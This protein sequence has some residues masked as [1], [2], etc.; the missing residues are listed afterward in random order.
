MPR[1]RNSSILVVLAGLS[2][3][4]VFIYVKLLP[5]LGSFS[6][7]L[8]GGLQ[9][10][11]ERV[12]VPPGE[13]AINNPAVENRIHNQGNLQVEAGV[14]QN[15]DTNQIKQDFKPQKKVE[16]EDDDDN[17]GLKGWNFLW[18]KGNSGKDGNEENDVC[19]KRRAIK[20]FKSMATSFGKKFYENVPIFVNSSNL[21]FPESQE[22]QLPFGIDGSEDKFLDAL[23][24]L[25]KTDLPTEITNASCSRCIIVG[26]GGIIKDKKLGSTIDKYDIVMRVN[27]GLVYGYESDVGSR[28]TLRVSH[29]EG[30]PIRLDDYDPDA[31]FVLVVFKAPDIE[32]AKRVAASEKA[33]FS[34]IK[35]GFWKGVARSVPKQPEKFR[36]LSP[37]IVKET[38]FEHVKFPSFEGKMF[39]NVPTTGT[40][41]IVMAIRL[42]DTVDVAGFGFD[43]R[44]PHSPL[45]Y[46]E[47]TPMSVVR[48]LKTHD[49]TLEKEFLRDL[50]EHRVI[51]D[52]T[53][54]LSWI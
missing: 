31:M 39:K 32:W 46:Y 17:V 28:T 25:T 24:V 38:A 19:K 37:A 27:G 16:E 29:P 3:L 13:S 33:D 26:S 51:N 22:F 5:D 54:G 10:H 9:H 18:N 15:I 43:F 53:G 7:D 40:V 8:T 44:N 6:D 48:H 34:D 14:R 50:V 35:G 1:L 11:N 4:F 49:L 45:H 41:A 36:I 23:K 2:T 30:A 42:C 12:R 52:L 47:N 21:H 20:R